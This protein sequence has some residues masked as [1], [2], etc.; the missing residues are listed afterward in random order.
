MQNLTLFDGPTLRDAGIKLAEW[1]RTLLCEAVDKAIGMLADACNRFTAED[2][3]SMLGHYVRDHQDISKVIGGR[4]RA[5][6]LA[7]LIETD[8]ATVQAR[9]PE[10][11]ARRMLLW[12]GKAEQLQVTA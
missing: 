5:A 8:G 12:Q 11:H 1:E 9:R 10:A 3:R 4:I 6:A 2:V 7:D